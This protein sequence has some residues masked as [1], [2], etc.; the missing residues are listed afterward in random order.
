MEG[1][2]DHDRG[3]R[4]QDEPIEVELGDRL[5][6]EGERE[7]R[8]CCQLRHL[9]EEKEDADDGTGGKVDVETYDQ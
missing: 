9:E 3:G 6:C 8:L 1:Q 5:S 7:R 2:Q 4:E